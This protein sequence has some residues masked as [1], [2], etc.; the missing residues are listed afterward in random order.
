[1]KVLGAKVED[2]LYDRFADLD[3]SI[4]DNL[5]AAVEMYLESMVNK[6]LT[7]HTSSIPLKPYDIVVEEVDWLIIRY[8]N[9]LECD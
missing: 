6:P 3:G 8:F 7:T 4:S 5:K 9:D 2:S 1:M